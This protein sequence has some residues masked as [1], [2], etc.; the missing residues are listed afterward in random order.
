MKKGK[1]YYRT[2]D[3]KPYTVIGSETRTPLGTIL[4]NTYHVLAEVGND[5]NIVRVLDRLN[6]NTTRDWATNEK[7][8]ISNKIK[9]LENEIVMLSARQIN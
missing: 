2:S 5:K 9:L 7:I 4:E 6:I 1:R 3:L 8:A